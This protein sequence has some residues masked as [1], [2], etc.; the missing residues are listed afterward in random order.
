MRW[1][2]KM[3]VQNLLALWPFLF[4]FFYF[5]HCCEK[6]FLAVT[7]TFFLST[8]KIFTFNSCI[9]LLLEIIVKTFK[10]TRMKKMKMAE[11]ISQQA[12]VKVLAILRNISEILSFKWLT[13]IYWYQIGKF[14]FI[15]HS[16]CR[17]LWLS[18]CSLHQLLYS[19]MFMVQISRVTIFW[20]YPEHVQ[21][22]ET[23]IGFMKCCFFKLQLP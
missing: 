8:V 22:L 5:C 19:P 9:L 7:P 3:A 2:P 14:T 13:N 12:I 15:H 23:L 11:N 21:C 10:E 6:I 17:F 18:F 1:Y 16:A 20:F 4:C